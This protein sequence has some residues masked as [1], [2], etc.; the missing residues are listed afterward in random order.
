MIELPEQPEQKEHRT[1]ALIGW[2]S[3]D[4]VF[5]ECR[6]GEHHIVASD[7]LQKH[8][9]SVQMKREQ[10]TLM[11]KHG[12][13]G[14]RDSLSYMKWIPLGTYMEGMSD[15]ADYF[16]IRNGTGITTEQYQWCQDNKSLLSPSQIHMINVYLTDNEVGLETI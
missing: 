14:E 10:M 4:G 1:N 9:Q 5:Y 12:Y 16:F 2:L 6:Y 11:K 15:D 8:E 13:M 3:P 7:I